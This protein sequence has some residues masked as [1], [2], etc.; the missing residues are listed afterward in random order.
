MESSSHIETRKSN[1]SVIVDDEKF[2]R[3]VDLTVDSPPKLNE[4]QFNNYNNTFDTGT[5]S[6]VTS[7]TSSSD[8]ILL[9]NNSRVIINYLHNTIKLLC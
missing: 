9:S 6:S 5:I 1:P 7:W 4:T 2:I 3:C 8:D